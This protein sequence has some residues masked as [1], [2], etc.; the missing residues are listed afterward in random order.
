MVPGSPA[1]QSVRKRKFKSLNE[2]SYFESEFEALALVTKFVINFQHHL[3]YF[4]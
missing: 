3:N 2:I 1:P 4:I